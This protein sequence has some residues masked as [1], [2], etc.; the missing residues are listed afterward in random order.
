M[1]ASALVRVLLGDQRFDLRDRPGHGTVRLRFRE[2]GRGL[3]A[4]SKA[5]DI[6]V[7]DI[8]ALLLHR[9]GRALGGDKAF[10]RRHRHGIGARE[11]ILGVIMAV[12]IARHAVAAAVLKADVQR[13]GVARDGK[14]FAVADGDVQRF[15]GAVEIQI[16]LSRLIGSR[17]R[18]GRGRLGRSDRTHG[19]RRSG[20]GRGERRFAA[21]AQIQHRH[22][23]QRDDQQRDD[24]QK[25]A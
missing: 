3:A 7:C 21:G 11:N 14:A 2:S 6:L 13:K 16:K 22:R 5:S 4:L 1:I 15:G 25:H 8:V 10:Q 19:R 12:D 9:A 23:D 17:F 18:S 20:L 24:R